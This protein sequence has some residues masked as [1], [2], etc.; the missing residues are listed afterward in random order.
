[1]VRRVEKVVGLE[2]LVALDDPGGERV[3]V[4]GRVDP[5]LGHVLAVELD[6]AGD[7]AEVA[8]DIRDAQVAHGELGA[9]VGRIDLPGLGERGRQP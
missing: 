5:G 9:G 3:D 4:N 1:M 6:G 8:A 2:V 7:R